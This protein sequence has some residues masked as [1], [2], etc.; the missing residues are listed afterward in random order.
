MCVYACHMRGWA[1][2]TGG[3]VDSIYKETHRSGKWSVNHIMYILVY[4]EHGSVK[5]SK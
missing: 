3:G 5:H 1:R 4:I 2:A